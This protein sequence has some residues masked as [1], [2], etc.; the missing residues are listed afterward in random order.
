[1]GT[2]HIQ[3]N[4]T[5]TSGVSTADDWTAANCYATS[6][7]VIAEAGS[8]NHTLIYDD[9]QHEIATE[10]FKSTFF[11]GDK[12]L[13]SR[14]GDPSLCKLFQTSDQ[15]LFLA[16]TASAGT[17]T[18]N[19]IHLGRDADQDVTGLASVL[20]QLGS[21]LTAANFNNCWVGGF[22]FDLDTTSSSGLLLRVLASGLTTTFTGGKFYDMTIDGADGGYHPGVRLQ[23]GSLIFDGTEFTNI[24]RT[25]AVFDGGGFV[26]NEGGT[27]TLENTYTDGIDFTTGTGLTHRPFIYS[28][29]TAASS[30]VL[31]NNVG[32][33]LTMT[34]GQG[35]AF[36]AVCAGGYE[37]NGLIIENGASYPDSNATGGCF[38]AKDSTSSGTYKNV[39]CINSRSHFG[40][41]WYGVGGGAGTL[42][43]VA[44]VNSSL[45]QGAVYSGGDG[46]LTVQGY[47]ASNLNSLD[48]GNAN[49]ADGLGLYAHINSSTGTRSK[50]VTVDD[51]TIE[52][53]TNTDGTVS[54]IFFRNQN[55]TYTL[56]V[57]MTNVACINNSSSGYA[58]GTNNT[59][60]GTTAI[61]LDI[62]TVSGG[63]SDIDETN[64]TLTNYIGFD[65]TKTAVGAVA[66]KGLSKNPAIRGITSGMI[67]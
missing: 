10:N 4:G 57:G 32:R 41:L 7:L 62:A 66:M 45:K 55:T 3:L 2:Y 26:W 17:L 30:L 53:C 28:E 19:N 63:Q 12:V 52:D 1:M 22:D 47:Y 18:V 35:G 9:G 36:Y 37:V 39:I 60:T 20:I 58:I 43:N 31:K 50:Q 23:L 42:E 34:N 54:G 5:R 51:V 46:D 67:G 11:A 65:A 25:L 27:L 21:G 33:N 40:T 13:S 59:D 6:E 15:R 49:E 56:T 14:N 38:L 16:N 48:E 44:I 64:I 61:T 24:S 8:G 29:N